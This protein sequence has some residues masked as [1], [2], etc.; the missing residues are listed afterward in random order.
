[1]PSI[2]VTPVYL[3]SYEISTGVI[4]VYRVDLSGSGLSSIKSI[5]IEDDGIVSGGR[6]SASG[7]DL[8]FIRISTQLALN[9]TGATGAQTLNGI[10]D[11][12][13][14]VSS[15]V[16][17][18]PGYKQPT[19][20]TDDPGW[21]TSLFIG[22]SATSGVDLA[23]TRF[24]KVDG[25]NGPG[26]GALSLGEGGAVSFTL[27][28]PITPV[29]GGG[30]Y[31]YFADLGGG[32]DGAYV[33]L[34]DGAPNVAKT[35]VTLSG[36]VVDDD[37]RLQQG[38]NVTLGAGNDVISGG[39]GNDTLGGGAGNDTLN[40]GTGNDA[41]DGGTGIDTAVFLGKWSAATIRLGAGNGTVTTSGEGT[42]QL[43]GIERI[44]FD[45]GVVLTDLGSNGATAYR[46]Y[47]AALGR[48]PDEGGLRVQAGALDGGI[49]GLQLA[50]NFLGAAEFT[51]RFGAT[52]NNSDFATKMYANI[53]G[54][55][56][57]PAG[58][59]VQ[60]DALNAGLSRAQLLLNFAEAAENVQLT[61]TATA[62]GLFSP[63]PDPAY[64]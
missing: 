18:R 40:G 15:A 29:N 27:K 42:D 24:D 62:N 55:E 53:L 16:G 45:D 37:I 5:V 6:G 3:G 61:G 54:R 7:F 4:G 14:F 50:Q 8:D 47:Q 35:G 58:L 60:V 57:D 38:I 9:A 46:L 64:G 32:N 39:A 26:P 34:S 11:A 59:K 2:R 23:A 20:T 10:V 17:F 63:I 31:L 48:A 51:Q 43:T 44:R 56:P 25:V 41:L 22:Q 12:F 19:L 52:L 36:T 49:S 28:A 1:V 33:T 13:D 30:P 21:K